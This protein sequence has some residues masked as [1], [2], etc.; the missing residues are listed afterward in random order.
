MWRDLWVCRC[1]FFA[2]QS[3]V[4]STF[5]DL[6]SNIWLSIYGFIMLPSSLPLLEGGEGGESFHGEAFGFMCL[7]M[8]IYIYILWKY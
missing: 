1:E 2:Y 6:Q 7:Y 8:Y 4:W 5:Y 3:V